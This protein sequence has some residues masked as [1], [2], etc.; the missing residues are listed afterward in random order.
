M[1]NAGTVMRFLPPVAA[2]ADGAVRFDG[3]PRS[4]ERPLNGVID[5]LRTLGARIDDDGRGSLPLT[6]SA[7]VR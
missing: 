3:D 4:H 7:A 6:V 1:G 5:A 2:L